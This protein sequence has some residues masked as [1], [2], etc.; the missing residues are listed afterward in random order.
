MTNLELFCPC[1][2]VACQSGSSISKVC[3]AHKNKT[4][5]KEYIWTSLRRPNWAQKKVAIVE[6][7]KQEWMSRM[8]AKKMAAVERWP[9]WRGSRLWRFD[10][11]AKWLQRAWLNQLTRD[12][13]MSSSELEKRNKPS[14]TPKDTLCLNKQT[15]RLTDWLTHW[16]TDW[17]TNWLTD[18]PTNW[19]SDWLTDWLTD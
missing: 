12:S 5:R 14:L 2:S 11:I 7:W 15:N 1:S 4:N 18:W 19:L 9:L 16:L 13:S 8:S 6:R 3:D 17:L 10:C